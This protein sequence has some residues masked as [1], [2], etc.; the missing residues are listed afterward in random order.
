MA[1]YVSAYPFPKKICTNSWLT[2]N[3]PTTTGK[4][5]IQLKS[6]DVF[7]TLLTS[8][9]LPWACK[10]VILGKRTA[11]KVATK[12]IKIEFRFTA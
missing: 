7:I 10:L 5:N 1:T 8:A 2:S 11:L 4:V 6:I 3:T 9:R 12:L